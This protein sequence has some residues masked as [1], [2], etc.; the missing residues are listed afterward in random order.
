MFGVWL[1]G[2]VFVP[3]NARQ[4]QAELDHVSR[5]HGARMRDQLCWGARLGP[6]RPRSMS[7]TQPLSP[8]RREPPGDRSPSCRRTLGTWNCSTA[9]SVRYGAGPPIRLGHHRP[10]WYPCPWRSMQASI[11]SC[12]VCGPELPW[13]SWTA[14]A[15]TEFA[16]ACRPILHSL[17]RPAASR[18]GDARRRRQRGRSRAAPLREEHHRAVVAPRGAS[19]HGEVR[20]DGTQWLWPG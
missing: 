19:I 6:R 17:H 8:G 15:P 3:A 4:P 11:T 9:S 12:S 13:C 10:T 7:P 18:H 1:A 16:D 5:V 14:S 20:R 2:A